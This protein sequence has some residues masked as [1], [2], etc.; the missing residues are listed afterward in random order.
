MGR[1]YSAASFE[2]VIVDVPISLSMT[3]GLWTRVMSQF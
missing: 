3:R 1:V 2:W